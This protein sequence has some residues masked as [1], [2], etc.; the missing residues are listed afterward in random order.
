MNGQSSMINGGGAAGVAAARVLPGY[1][2]TSLR[3]YQ[4]FIELPYNLGWQ[5]RTEPTLLSPA[6]FFAP[7]LHHAFDKSTP[8]RPRCGIPL[9]Y[10]RT[11]SGRPP[12]YP[13]TDAYY[14]RAQAGRWGVGNTDPVYAPLCIYGYPLPGLPI[15]RPERTPIRL[16]HMQLDYAWA[17]LELPDSDFQLTCRSSP[18]VGCARLVYGCSHASLMLRCGRIGERDR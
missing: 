13:R 5:R 11:C 17:Y 18:F 12:D 4:V 14:P 10:F 8:C 1:F 16:Q 7:R 3:V 9:V 15:R 2:R 6:T